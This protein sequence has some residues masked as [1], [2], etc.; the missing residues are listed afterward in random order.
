MKVWIFNELIFIAEIFDSDINSIMKVVSNIEK[1]YLIDK[2]NDNFRIK[3]M[4]AAKTMQ[5]AINFTNSSS[6][7]NNRMR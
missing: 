2:V 3:K 6:L 4:S 7:A 1:D 5:G